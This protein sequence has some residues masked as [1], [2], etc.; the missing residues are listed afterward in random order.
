MGWVEGGGEG[1]DGR[2]SFAY[3]LVHPVVA[4]LIKVEAVLPLLIMVVVVVVVPAVLVCAV[5]E[6]W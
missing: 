4:R 3:L 5:S 6:S 1:W 2:Q